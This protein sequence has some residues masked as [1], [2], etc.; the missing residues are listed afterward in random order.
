MLRSF[1]NIRIIK[2]IIYRLKKIAPTLNVYARCKYS[3]NLIYVP[4]DDFIGYELYFWGTFEDHLV[5]LLSHNKFN[6]L[7][8]FDVGTNLGTFTFNLEPIFK[9]IVCFEASNKNCEYLT[10]SIK[11]N[12]LSSKVALKHCA[13]SNVSYEKISLNISANTCGNNSIFT[14]GEPNKSTELVETLS[15]DDYAENE[16][17]HPDLI[18]V[19]IEGAE[20]LFFEGAYNVI[21]KDKPVILVEWNG[22]VCK[23]VGTSIIDYWPIFDNDFKTFIVNEKSDL[24]EFKYDDTKDYYDVVMDLLITP[25]SILKTISDL[26]KS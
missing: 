6:S 5:K 24:V 23:N 20:K 11:R 19:D 26:I 8:F 16:N 21:K 1:L 3:N 17:I 10:E 13:I 22:Y 25:K 4:L 15:I 14:H 18:K 12:N 7:T 9:Q 2:S